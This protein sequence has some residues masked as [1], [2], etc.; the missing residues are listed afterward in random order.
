MKQFRGFTLIEFM[1]AMTL[2][3]LVLAALTATFVANSR[4]RTEIEKA[5]E[6]IENGRFALQ[7]LSDD[8]EM[9][10]FL[11]HLDIDLAVAAD[12]PMPIPGAKPNPCAVTLASLR[13]A[14]PMHLQG[15]NDL[16]ALDSDLDD[17]LTDFKAGTDI[18]VIRRV[19]TCVGGS[20]N[21]AMVAGAP[22]FQ[23][24]L[25]DTQLGSLNYADYFRLETTV[26]NLNRTNR[27]CTTTAQRRQFLVH[28]Y[29][30]ANND[31]AGD[32]VPTLKRAELGATGGAIA[33]TIVP[34]A[35]GIEDLQVEYGIDTTGDGAPDAFTSSGDTYDAPG[36]GAGPFANCAA[37]AAECIANWRNTVAIRMNLLAR[38]TSVTRDYVDSKVYILGANDDGTERCARDTDDDGTCEAFN[39]GYKRH[40][41]Q[42]SV[43][44]NNPAGRRE[45]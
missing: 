5:N 11:S 20:A 9:A 15:Y 42:T 4:S 18:V 14:L 33:F 36:G 17:C 25:C 19:A 34:L 26:A 2:S 32:N 16:S 30:I 8:L 13:A 35:H 43:R 29:F 45:S 39:N 10:G 1:I 31:L 40:V 23:A 28:I 12:T 7:I 41:Y 24:A 6:Q 22:Y 27:N 21:C 3:L 38:N 44:L 37:H